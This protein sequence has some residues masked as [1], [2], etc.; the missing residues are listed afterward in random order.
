MMLT[1]FI[2]DNDDCTSNEDNLL[3]RLRSGLREHCQGMFRWVQI[4]LD[5]CLPLI[6]PHIVH[7]RKI[8]EG[9]LA[10]LKKDGT[11]DIT[12]Y[13]LLEKA[14]QRLWDFNCPPDPQEQKTRDTLFHIALASFQN[15]SIGT[16]L[17]ALAIAEEESEQNIQM[18]R[19]LQLCSGFL[20]HRNPHYYRPG[21]IYLRPGVTVH[22]YF[23]ELY[24]VHASA[25]AF[26]S[27]MPVKQ[28][29]Q[30]VETGGS[31]LEFNER[32]S[33]S[34]I[35]DIFLKVVGN[36]NHR[37]WTCEW[38]HKTDHHCT[39]DRF[40]VRANDCRARDWILSLE[41]PNS[42]YTSYN[43]LLDYLIKWGWQHCRLAAR[44]ASIFDPL[45][46]E[47]LNQVLISPMSAF[48]IMVLRQDTD[49][50]RH[51]PF[52]LQ[53]HPESGELR[54][55]FSHV[56]AWLNI[57]HEDDIPKLFSPTADPQIRQ[58][59]ESS[60]HVGGLLTIELQKETRALLDEN[61]TDTYYCA[62]ALELAVL[63]RNE[64]AVELILQIRKPKGKSSGYYSQES[65]YVE[66]DSKVLWL[67]AAMKM[68]AIVTLLLEKS[69]ANADSL[70]QQ[71]KEPANRSNITRA[72]R[73]FETSQPSETLL[74]WAEKNQD[75][76][77]LQMDHSRAL[78][79]EANAAQVETMQR[80]VFRF[81]F[82]LFGC[83]CL[84]VL[85]N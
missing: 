46:N 45:W 41:R 43:D 9:H 61:V 28:S 80:R 27:E 40:I 71:V 11:S 84:Y 72:L 82:L 38:T 32:S 15:L 85:S 52:F 44:Q 37:L 68:Y 60:A 14:Y 59:F 79:A 29:M 16:L 55:L 2:A 65:P 35:A 10:Q 30:R 21:V 17:D 47:V 18:G 31:D 69:E 24:W 67:A 56:I 39:P 64:A 6:T 63:E 53:P 51:H 3:E 81:L 48:I 22:R 62:S 49:W 83:I 73:V 36:W 23:H 4:W 77:L 75:D 42:L 12:P 76:R 8:A 5:I 58:H 54:I 33:H 1:G 20:D 78:I 13:N 26:V 19:L 25:R 34:I 57:I 50:A 74:T 7:A 66:M 70:W